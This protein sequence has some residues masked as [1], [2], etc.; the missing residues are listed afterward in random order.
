MNE[1]NKIIELKTYINKR[2]KKNRFKN[3]KILKKIALIVAI[4]LLN[5]FN[6]LNAVN[7]NSIDSAYMHSLGD[8]GSL[9]TYNGVPVK[10]T[11]IAYTKDGVEYPA[12][13]MDKTKLRS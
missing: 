13:C 8:C 7:A 10:V 9:L 11:Y 3:N 1:N 12:Y 4:V 6:F 2:K 5:T